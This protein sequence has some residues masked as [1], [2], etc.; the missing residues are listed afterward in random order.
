[1]KNG[2]VDSWSIH[3]IA[4]RTVG[5]FLI[6]KQATDFLLIIL[7]INKL[8]FLTLMHFNDSDIMN[9]S[10]WIILAE[11]ILHYFHTKE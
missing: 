9:D 2:V 5:K 7:P 3:Q 11:I 6:L 1:M 4:L 10:F 8:K